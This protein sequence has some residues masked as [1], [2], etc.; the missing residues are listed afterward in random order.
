MSRWKAERTRATQRVSVNHSVP[1]MSGASF[2]PLLG[3][4]VLGNAESSVL[5]GKGTRLGSLGSLTLS[6]SNLDSE[7]SSHIPGVLSCRPAAHSLASAHLCGQSGWSLGRGPGQ[8]M[9][10]NSS[11]IFLS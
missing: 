7:R 3:S 4:D 9:K 2:S 6:V 1:Q 11:F 5:W 8:G 10:E